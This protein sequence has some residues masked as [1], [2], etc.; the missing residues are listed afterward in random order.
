M[1]TIFALDVSASTGG[2]RNYWQHVHSILEEYKS[3]ID[4]YLVWNHTVC[5]SSIKD[6]NNYIQNCR[7]TGGTDPKCITTQLRNDDRLIFITDGDID[8]KDVM[9]VNTSMTNIKLSRC[10]AHIIAPK[11]DLSVVCGFTR[12]VESS[13]RTYVNDNVCTIS[14]ITATDLNMDIGML[15]LEDFIDKYDKIR[16]ILLNKMIGITTMNKTL[17]DTL[18]A[19]K[20]KLYRQFVASIQPE[21]TDIDSDLSQGQYANAKATSLRIINK[22]YGESPIIEFSKKFD[23]LIQIV[24]GKTNF[25]INQFNPIQS[26]AY[27]TAYTV[28]EAEPETLSIDNV[29]QMECPIMMDMDAPVIPIL[30]GEPVLYGVDKNVM[31]VIISNPLSIL[32]NREIVDK[33]KTRLGSSIGLYTFC[34]LAKTTNEHPMSRSPMTGCIPLGSNIAYVN[35]ASKAMMHLFT[36]GKILGNIDLYFAVI[37]FV[38]KDLEYLH[39][40]SEHVTEQM[41]YRMDHHKTSASLSGLPELVGT[42]LRFKEAIWFV[43]TS[44]NLFTDNAIIPFRQHAFVYNQLL[45]LNALNG[46]TISEE[47]LLYNTMTVKMLTMLHD[48]KQNVAL[49]RNKIRAQYQAH[50][51]IDG[52]YVF[53]PQLLPNITDEVKLNYAIAKIIS[54]S[55][56]ASSI[57]VNDIVFE[58]LPEIVDVW[59]SGEFQHYSC[60]ISPKTCRPLYLLPDNRTWLESYNSFHTNSLKMLSMNK[61]FGDFV[62]KEHRY[63]TQSEFILYIWKRETGKGETNLPKTIERSATLIMQDYSDIIKTIPVDEFIHKFEKSVS[64]TTRIEMEH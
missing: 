64:R 46:Y 47:D 54:P 17:H 7:G 8:T 45:A 30:E 52:E 9:A 16:Q 18:I 19:L 11:P 10:D 51:I 44:G 6:I 14:T 3:M 61:Y 48:S 4:V 22:Y 33:I 57:S 27:S 12:G 43:L 56:S 60:T 5:C 62:C 38:I 28:S 34:E 32:L 13:I 35:D 29:R 55:K 2:N 36:G 53:L 49:F 39:I 40:V 20:K 24:S 50:I 26:N 23:A 42:K 59:E 63:P 41:I 25:S 37:Y 31:K 21:S 1:R 58:E 15:T